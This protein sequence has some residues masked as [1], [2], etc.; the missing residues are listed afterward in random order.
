MAIIEGEKNE[1]RFACRRRAGSRPVGDLRARRVLHQSHRDE[2]S[3]RRR[4]RHDHVHVRRGVPSA[5]EPG[6]GGRPRPGRMDRAQGLEREGQGEDQA[7]AAHVRGRRSHERAPAR[8]RRDHLHGAGGAHQSGR[9]AALL[10]A[11]ED[12]APEGEDGS[13]GRRS[14]RRSRGGIRLR[15]RGRIDIDRRSE[16]GVAHGD[17]RA[18]PGRQGREL[19]GPARARRLLSARTPTNRASGSSRSTTRRTASTRRA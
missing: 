3:V 19:G 6:A 17:H 8:D 11:H 4:L 14:H 15:E 5:P 2:G 1:E 13:R 18:G 16:R 7:G 9:P 12:R 10:V